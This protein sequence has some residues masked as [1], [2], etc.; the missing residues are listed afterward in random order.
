MGE[1]VKGEAPAPPA[2]QRMLRALLCPSQLN[3]IPMIFSVFAAFFQAEAGS[4]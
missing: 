4:R 3:L 1:G 2:S